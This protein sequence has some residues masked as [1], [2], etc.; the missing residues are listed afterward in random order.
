M[1]PKNHQI[2]M[3]TRSDLQWISDVKKCWKALSES[4][5]KLIYSDESAFFNLLK[6]H[7]QIVPYLFY[8]SFDDVIAVELLINNNDKLNVLA[9][10]HPDHRRQGLHRILLK[11]IQSDYH[12]KRISVKIK[13]VNSDGWKNFWI[14]NGFR[15]VDHYDD[16]SEY[17]REDVEIINN[18]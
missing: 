8:D 15:L 4:D 10:T 13:D 5:K 1:I 16:Q 12:G 17:V 2:K 14:R 6:N 11:E 9:F 3:N 7:N 18:R